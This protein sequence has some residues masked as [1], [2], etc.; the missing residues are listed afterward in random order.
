MKEKHLSFLFFILFLIIP[1]GTHAETSP[2]VELFSPQG[3]V[4]GV[5]QVSVRFSEQIVPLGNPRAMVEPFEIS[6]PP[7]EKGSQ[8]WADGKNWVF[9]FERDLP[10]GVRCE[11]TLKPGLKTLEGKTLT[12]Q[13]R[14]EFS[15]GGPAILR[16]YPYEGSFHIEEGQAFVLVLDAPAV[17]ESLLE[18][19]F[20]SVAGISERVGVDLLAED[21]KREILKS[22]R[23]KKTDTVVALRARR[24]FPEDTKISLVWGKGVMTA[25]GVPTVQDQVLNFK[26]RG[27]FRAEFSCERENAR[28][29]CMPISTMRL[30]FT[31]PIPWKDASRIVLKGPGDAVWKAMKRPDEKEEGDKKEGGKDDP[32]L[33]VDS[34]YFHAPFPQNSEFRIELPGVISDDSGR[35]LS[36]IDEFPLTVQTG[37]FPPLA[38]FASRFGILELNA[39]PA[40][41]LT[42]R[43]IEPSVAARLLKLQDGAKQKTEGNGFFESIKGKLFRAG[44]GLKDTTGDIIEWLIKVQTYD[45]NSWYSRERSLFISTDKVQNISIPRPGGPKAFEVVGIPFKEPGFYV[46]EVESPILGK[47]LLESN[48]PMYVP[49][50]VLVT[51]LSV[52]FKWGRESSLV[53][54]TTLDE[55]KP[56]RDADVE[57]RD[58]S[59]KVLWTGKTD[60]AGVARMGGLP[61]GKKT[62]QGMKMYGQGLFVTAR[63]GED[64]SFVHSDWN[65]GI[66]PWRF[67]LPSEYYHE[68]G[69][70]HTVFDRTLLRAGEKVHLKHIFRNHHQYGFSVIPQAELPKKAIIMHYGS[71]QK[72][73]FPL[74]WDANGIAETSWD[75][76]KDARLGN[77]EVIL[78]N[79]AEGVQND[80]DYYYQ[81]PGVWH[82]GLF[83]VEEFRV[84][85]MKGL[86]QPPSGPLIS[87]SGVKLDL[88]VKYFAGGG[89]SGANVRLRSQVQQRYVHFEEFDGF[90]FA[91]GRLK[92]GLTKSGSDMWTADESEEQQAAKEGAQIKTTDLT[93]DPSGG[94]RAEVIG[95]PPLEKPS[96]FLT[97]LE[98]KD[99]NGETQ[100]VSSKVALWPSKWLVGIKP[101]SWVLSKDSLKFQL[102]V[103]DTSGRPVEGAFVKAD[104][105][106]RKSYSHR[107]RLVGG[108]YAY[109]HVQETKSL[110]KNVCE[111]RTGKK[112]ILFCETKPPRSG[113]MIIQASA[114]DEAGKEV[115]AHN[116]VWVAGDG[117]WWFEVADSDRIDIL[118]EKN[119]Y[120]PGE[121]AKFQVRMPFRN[122]TALVTVEREGVIEIF[123]KEL[124]GKEPVIKVPIKPHYAPNVFISAF[125]VRGRVSGVKPTAMVDLGRPA[126]KLGIKEI[127]VGWRGHELKVK[128]SSDKD[129][130]KVWEK[131]KARISVKTAEGKLP[132]SGTEV[133]MAVVDEGL[134]ELQENKSWDILSAMMG[135]RPYELTTSTAQM[136]V[137][138]KRHFGL[139]AL[140]HG[141]GG[142]KKSTRELFDT[143]LLWKGRVVLDPNGEAIVEFPL[144]DSITSFRIAA[145]ATGGAGLFGAGYASIRTS[146]DLMLFSGIAPVVREGDEF[147][148]LFT[149]RNASD[150]KMDLEVSGRVSGGELGPERLQLEAGEAREISW[151]IK[152]PTGV[153]SILYEVEARDKEGAYDSIKVKQNV[154]TAVPVRTF[155]ATIT[156]VDKDYSLAVKRPEDSVPGKGGV[157]VTL[158]RTLSEGLGGVTEYMRNYPYTCLEQK[159][160]RAVALKDRKLWE[161]IVAEMPA[162]LDGDG[163]AKYFPSVELGSDVLTSYIISVSHEAGWEL[164]Y[165]LKSRMAEGLKKFVD[166]SIIRWNP[167][168]TADLSIRK[169]AAIEALSRIGE[170][171]P[172]ML[173][174]ISIEPNLWPTSA[175][176][177]WFNILKRLEGIKDREKMTSWAEQILRSRLNF[178]GTT[179]GFSTEDM[180]RLWWL[181]I[182]ADMNAVKLILSIADSP[183]W[184]EDMPRLVRGA[185]SRQR[186]GAWDLTTS[187][188]WSVLAFDKFSSVFE[189]DP[190]SGKTEA[191]TSLEAR[192]HD[193]SAASTGALDFKWPQESDTLSIKHEGKGR[194]WATV[195]SLAAIPLKEPFSSGYSIKKMFAPVEQKEKG[196]WSRG[197]IVRVRIEITSQADMTWVAVNDPVPSGATILGSGLGRDSALSTRG[198]KSSGWAYPAYTERTFEAFR[199]YYEFMPKGT[200]ALEYTMRLNQSGR[201]SLPTTRVEALYSPE[202]LGELPN[203][204]FVVH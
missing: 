106:E 61:D 113:S 53:W 184:K 19:V 58:C 78:S 125:V 190:V 69:I 120:E 101:D 185:L 5:R 84:P 65:E 135:R 6:C 99:P 100:T 187:N 178:Q 81:M 27:P 117:D 148:S 89:A 194:P 4:K 79:E 169:L 142:G 90:V 196:R 152:A 127:N 141:G 85:L 183:Q 143:L 62:C 191:K 130:Y 112:G 94:A 121:V 41:A 40:L 70:A 176:L 21:E 43:N 193:W 16:S 1:F 74:K 102:A 25:S 186:K 151:N 189:K 110:L 192:S 198:E 154:S 131:A 18:N 114:V 59:G 109:E 48:R 38:K 104:L 57:I 139:K 111:G 161:S 97:E 22:I 13:S 31:S 29:A 156:Q 39:Q 98:F 133:A 60:Q 72:Y 140:P 26:T 47:S 150:R 76:P 8:M 2:H 168:P 123:V 55:G 50:A 129:A 108:F 63:L 158:R 167:L 96:E 119:R 166:G 165:N 35:K 124:S 88:A 174:S 202:M 155:Q 157:K 160:S 132:P 164:P 49:A 86:I 162:Y 24:N 200:M 28:A 3:T 33:T 54:V 144:N 42:V 153:D 118:P 23:V 37:D 175:V 75:I 11:F 134:L 17:K 30:I 64:L 80:A 45:W 82:S 91:N 204:D 179:M 32:G 107:K 66:E 93:L 87:P 14:F 122:A 170:A 92:E 146:Q 138:G 34:V 137:V 44:E 180:D 103:V 20:F 15:T 171:K 128:V 199:S 36:N 56:V 197:D 68:P 67:Q 182:S 71:G 147:N 203:E 173:G 83:R 188:A 105:F 201:F 77:Y 136:H 126:Y 52:H 12:G 116:D 95:L 115:T 7:Q 149:V 73:E 163:L 195:Q 172:E 159:V 145:V 177:D 10:A 51:N 46:V 9:N 181:M